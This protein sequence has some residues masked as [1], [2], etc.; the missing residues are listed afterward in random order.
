MNKQELIE[1]IGS[2]DKLYGEKYYVALDD[3][4]DLVKQLDEPEKVV[5]PQFV[6]GWIEEARKSCKDVADFF[7]FDFTNE[8][9]GKW[10]MQE[11]PFDLAAR[12]WLDG[13]EVEK[14]KR[15][16]VKVKGICGNHETLNREKH[17]NKWLFSDRE[18]NSL[19][20]TH[21]TRKELEDAGFS[22]VFN[23]PLFEVEE[24]E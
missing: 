18:E 11:R 24:V 4:L 19:Y 10:F 13:Y 20:G 12:V 1:K 5:V 7:D 2:L 17:S 23:S 3:V 22:E 8:E 14:E 15:Y 9:V 6:A 16:R 21:H